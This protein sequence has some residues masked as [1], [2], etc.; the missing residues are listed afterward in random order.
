MLKK[1]SFT[2]GPG[3]GLCL[4][5]GRNIVRKLCLEN[6]KKCIPVN[7]LEA[8]LLT[9]RLFQDIK[10]PFLVLLVSGGHCFTAVSYGIG[11]HQI[12]GETVDDSVGEAFGNLFFKLFGR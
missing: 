1:V 8:H 4:Q 11:D 10:F 9:A 5:E 7:H 12:I 3:L 6:N 2:L